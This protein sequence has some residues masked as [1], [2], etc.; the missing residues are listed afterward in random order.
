VGILGGVQRDPQL[1]L[2]VMIP[3]QTALAQYG[4]PATSNPASMLIE[5]RIGAAQQIA[6]QAPL[7]LRP[8]DPALRAARIEPAEALRR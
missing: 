3:D 4:D 7:D 8:D 1:L 5:T 6:S 2:S